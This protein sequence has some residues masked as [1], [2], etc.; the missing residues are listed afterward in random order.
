MTADMLEEEGIIPRA[1]AAVFSGL[2]DGIAVY[3][4][5]LQIY[6]EKVYDLL[7]KNTFDN[8]IEIRE[9]QDSIAHAEGLSEYIITKK[10]DCLELLL[11][12]EK[13]R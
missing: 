5:F 8:P 11:R 7:R 9:D 3:C 13:N 2:G 1:I 4:S 10:E 12:G 6:N